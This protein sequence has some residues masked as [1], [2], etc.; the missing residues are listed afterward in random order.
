MF[1]YIWLFI[2]WFKF[3]FFFIDIVKVKAFYEKQNKFIIFI[4]NIFKNNIYNLLGNASI[5]KNIIKFKLNIYNHII[6]SKNVIKF[7]FIIINLIYIIK[8]EIS[9]FSK[10]KL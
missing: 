7:I 3:N 2:C 1:K 4:N 9:K 6:N 8:N 10:V 5:I